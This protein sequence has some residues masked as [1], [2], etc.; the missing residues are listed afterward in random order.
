MMTS[1]TPMTTLTHCTRTSTDAW[2]ACNETCTRIFVPQL[3]MRPH[4]SWLKFWA[5]FHNHLHSIHG[6]LSTSTSFSCL[7]PSSSH[8][9]SCSLSSTTRSSW[10]THLPVDTVNSFI[11]PTGCEPNL[12][13]FGEL[14]DSSV[15]FMIP[16][17]DQD[18]DDLTLGEMLT[19]ACRGQVDHS[20]PEGMSVSQ[21]SSSAR[22]DGS[23]QSDGE[24]MVNH[25]R[26]S[27]VTFKVISVHSNFSEDIQTKKMVD[28]S[29][30]PDERNSSNTQIRALLEEQ[31]QTITAE[32][33]E[34]VGHHDFQAAQ[35]EEERRLLQGQ[36]WR[37]KL[38]F[39]EAHQ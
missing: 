8:T 26:K 17:S 7:P 32:Y 34:K 1:T 10:Q 36:L 27:G 12:L 11:S 5:H 24:R 38:E 37:Q 31:R 22:L 4:T 39:R 20:K 16:S 29:G 3:V 9:S 28:W 14:N 35:S 18:V 21:S 2:R 23:G 13:T 15:P 33:R 6:S 30:Q 19:Q 25:S